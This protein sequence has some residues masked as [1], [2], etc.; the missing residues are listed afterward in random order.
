MLHVQFLRVTPRARLEASGLPRD[1]LVGRYGSAPCP[2]RRDRIHSRSVTDPSGAVMPGAHAV[3]INADED[4]TPDDQRGDYILSPLAAGEHAC[5]QSKSDRVV[6]SK[7]YVHFDHGRYAMRDALDA[8]LT[9]F[10]VSTGSKQVVIF[11]VDGILSHGHISAA[12]KPAYPNSQPEF[13]LAI[14]P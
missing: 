1:E 11:F 10:N 8:H 7:N 9:S 4:G 14:R 5:A 12:Q 3:V 2:D 13:S 6:E